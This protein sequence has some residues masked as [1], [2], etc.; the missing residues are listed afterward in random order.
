MKKLL[1][2]AGLFFL[3]LVALPIFSS[4]QAQAHGTHKTPIDASYN[5]RIIDDSIFTNSGSMSIASI[6]A[7]LNA[8]VPTCRTGYTCLKD[9]T[10]N[11]KSAAQIIFE[12]A[13]A[14]G[15]NPQVILVTL[16]KEQ[17]LVTDDWPIAA[18]YQTA[19]GYGCPESQ[20]TC[21]AQYYGFTN[22]VTLGTKVM[23][24]GV[25]RN[26]GNSSSYPGWVIDPRWRLGNTTTVDGKATLIQTC[27]TG[28]LYSYTPHRPDSAYETAGD[29][30]HYYGNYNFV[31]LFSSWFGPT[32]G[33]SFTLVMADNG[34]LR[35]WVIHSGI[36]QHIPSEA[37]KLAWGLQNVTLNTMTGSYLGSITEGPQLGRLMRPHGSQDIYF[38]D[39]G[40][41]YK[42]TSPL[43]MAAWNFSVGAIS[44][45]SEGL[46]QV[47]TNSGNLAYSINN[48]T[49]PADIYLVDSGSKR[50]YSNTNIF[51]AWEGDGAGYTT[52]SDDY[53]GMMGN[54]S[55]VTSTKVSAGAG[56]QEYQVVAGQKL[57]ESANVAQLYPGV[58]VPNIS[59]AT[60][61]RL[62]TCAPASQ[63][64]RVT[65]A[66]T[67][68]MVDNGS[69]HA[70]S[71]IEVLRAWGIGVSPL[72]NIVTQGNLNLLAAGPALN[73]YQADVGGQ[74]YLMDGRKISVPSGLDSAYRKSGSVYAASQALIN[75]SP[76]GES[77]SNFLKGFNASPI[78]LMDN[79]ILR[80][81]STP[82][83]L[84]LW[85]N[86]ETITS[87][88]D[89]IISWF[90]SPG[91]AIGVYVS[92]GSDEYIT[93]A[94]KLHH[95]SPS[96]KTEWQLSNPVVL[97]AATITR[98]PKGDDLG[99]GFKN[100][101]NYYIVIKGNAYLTVDPNIAF[102][103]SLDP[104]V[105]QT[106][107]LA[108]VQEFLPVSTL[109]RFVRSSTDTRQFVVDS[110]TLYYLTPE[111]AA[112]FVT[113]N[114]LMMNIDPTGLTGSAWGSVVVR[115][116]S[117]SQYTGYFVIDGGG[118]RNFPNPES[119]SWWT[120]GASIPTVSNGFLNLLP[121]RG[122]VDRAVKG[123]GPN[124]YD[125]KSDSGVITKHWITNPAT[126]S[127]GYGVYQQVSDQLLNALPTGADIN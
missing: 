36:R 88:S 109:T 67:V 48:N 112:N 57:A 122:I 118:K 124:I 17:S 5:S 111:H 94:G 72:V 21:D 37:V 74:L 60:I 105:A 59:V 66:N 82:N 89:H 31:T 84:G 108:V 49:S 50:R 102:L 68:Y 38:V 65:G 63:F 119:H 75:L 34:D 96:V 90:G 91:T 10:E 125:V 9:F 18:Q 29:G 42:I 20:P 30:G 40:K 45:I 114:G 19:M 4:Q 106:M 64:I 51:A 78:F 1:L 71:S 24:V 62:V 7:F 77:A 99:T 95:I 101:G 52:V 69:S 93:E 70:V 81:I 11:G 43:M 107:S 35:Q 32:H 44:N 123:S 116:S 28:S 16:Q 120:S 80:N 127:S 104:A 110:H 46:A 3:A 26:C 13:S 86:G 103:W 126:F 39:S 23:R 56:Q 25:D 58:A 8:K 115:S 33:D 14:F 76:V 6:Q 121:N 113:S 22:Q 97:N 47:P 100:G 98:W 79:A 61:N 54:E 15:I 83:Q 12:Q 85:N 53:F 2:L 55:D 27:A 41:S 73:T 92:N 87:V 117:D